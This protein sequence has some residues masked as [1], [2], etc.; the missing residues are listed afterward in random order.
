MSW[1]VIVVGAGAA[2]AALAARLSEDAD[3]R[4]LLLE[5]GPDYRTADTPEAMRSP[6]PFN[7]ILPKHFQAYYMW[8]SLMASRT[9]RQAPRLLWRGRGVGGSTAIKDRKSVV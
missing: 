2:G 8:P 9:S 4:V 7:V 5:A 6:N 1:D 3:R